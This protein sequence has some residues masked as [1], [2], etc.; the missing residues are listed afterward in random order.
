MF[1][2]IVPE[3]VTTFANLIVRLAGPFF[4]IIALAAIGPGLL[5]ADLSVEITMALLLFIPSMQALSGEFQYVCD[6]MHT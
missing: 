6:K 2:C 1:T 3:D 4:L 5:I